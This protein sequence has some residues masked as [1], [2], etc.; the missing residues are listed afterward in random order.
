MVYILK[1]LTCRGGFEVLRSGK[2]PDLCDGVQA[3]LS[4]CASP[5]VLEA[6]NKFPHKVLLN[7]VPRM[8]MWPAQF[9]ESGV[10]EDNIGLYFFAKD[11]ERLTIADNFLLTLQCVLVYL[12]S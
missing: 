7:E 10:K 4:T 3:H 9:Q 8:S 2:V 5:K 11:F 12:F 6:A 1:I